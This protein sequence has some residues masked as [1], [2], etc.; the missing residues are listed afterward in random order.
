M[1]MRCHSVCET[2]SLD[3]LSLYELL[4]ASDSVVKAACFEVVCV[5]AS[6][7]VKPMSEILFWYIRCIPPFFPPIYSGHSAGTDAREGCSQVPRCAFL[8]DARNREEPRP[9]GRRSRSRTPPCRRAQ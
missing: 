1:T 2:Y 8:E 7:P 4:V 3:F 6:L 9:E 5:S